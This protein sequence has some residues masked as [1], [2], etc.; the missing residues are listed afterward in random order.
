[1][2]NEF[3]TRQPCDE[4]WKKFKS[5]TPMDFWDTTRRGDW[6]WWWLRFSVENVAPTQAQSVDFSQDCA[7]HHDYVY[8]AAAA[9]YAATAATTAANAANA[10]A[11]AANAA[12]DYATDDYATDDPTNAACA[13][14]IGRQAD[15]IREHIPFPFGTPPAKTA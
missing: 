12:A 6:L 11:N 10:A 7:N 5:M 13:A 15:W 9:A 14:E 1:M 4:G 2:W 3:F 8:A